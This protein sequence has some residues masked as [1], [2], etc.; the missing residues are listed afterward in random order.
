ME[1][2]SDEMLMQMVARNDLD[3]L[4][5]LFQRYKKR[6]YNYFLRLTFDP[7]LSEDLVQNVF[8]R[9]IKYKNSFNPEYPFKSWI[10]RIARNV[11]NDDYRAR[12]KV[13]DHVEITEIPGEV[14]TD[15]KSSEE[16]ERE[17]VLMKAIHQLPP[18]KRELIICSKFQGMKYEELAEIR[19]TTVGAI[20]VQV[21]RAMGQLKEI[22]F[23]Y[24]K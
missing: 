6:M 18:E 22:Y 23:Q 12:T 13:D 1:S 19:E 14:L 2:L 15:E 21:H 11:F 9:V 10:Y 4:K 24:E 5:H 3:Q 7:D 8:I 17:K 20:K 16:K